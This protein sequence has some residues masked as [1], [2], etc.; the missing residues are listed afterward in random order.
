MNYVA[1]Q[2]DGT[3]AAKMPTALGSVR[4]WVEQR[5]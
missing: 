3:D 1:Q 2:V 4:H 5:R